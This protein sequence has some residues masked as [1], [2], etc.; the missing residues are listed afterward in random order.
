M[1]E[2]FEDNIGKKMVDI[3]YVGENEAGIDNEDNLSVKLIDIEYVG[4]N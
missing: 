3:E 1:G 2:D 4:E